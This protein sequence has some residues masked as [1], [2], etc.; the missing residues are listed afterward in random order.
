MHLLPLFNMTVLLRL[1]ALFVP[2]SNA[3][4]GGTI[5]NAVGGGFTSWTGF[6]GAEGLVNTII[7]GASPLIYL[8]AI[9]AVV[10][11]GAEMIISQS[12]DTTA[13]A[14]RTFLGA[15]VGLVLLL[16]ATVTRN[17][18]L[19]VG[20]DGGTAGS[21]I[22]AELIGI[23]D[24][25]TAIVGALIILI[26]ITNG[27]KAIIQFGSGDGLNILRTTIINIVLGI[28]VISLRW[29][30]V[31][32]IETRQAQPLVVALIEYVN[33]TLTFI[34]TIAVLVVIYAGIMMIVN[35]GNEDQFNKSRN[36][37]VR[38]IIGIGIILL[39]SALVN[40][41]FAGVF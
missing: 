5:I 27:I 18:I 31:T 24:F 20:V 29:V 22:S 17:A 33:T 16:L 26:I 11:S 40:A 8:V 25:L 13:K 30:I 23:V 37:I 7:S 10:A 21:L 4:Q 14:R 3:Y 35:G 1:F 19:T 41:L 34:G 32:S 2:H 38:A 9:L 15:I 12:S 6:G 36:L 39:S 28:I